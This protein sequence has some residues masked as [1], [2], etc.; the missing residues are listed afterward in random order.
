M[1]TSSRLVPAARIMLALLGLGALG[2]CN[3]C[4]ESQVNQA[5]DI[6]GQVLERLQRLDSICLADRIQV[7]AAGGNLTFTPVLRNPGEAVS[8]A[9]RLQMQVSHPRGVEST[10]GRYAQLPSDTAYPAR[11]DYVVTER[12][13]SVTVPATP[14]ATY[15][16]DL[17]VWAALLPVPNSEDEDAVCHIR[18]YDHTPGQ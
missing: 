12:A 3:S 17:R 9:L 7:S 2:A 8:G 6:V 1:R 10:P 18:Q 5:T 11:A 15:V 4:T 14:G 16:V 13:A